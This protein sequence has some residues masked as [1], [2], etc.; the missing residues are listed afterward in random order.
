M[1][2]SVNTLFI[3]VGLDATFA[4]VSD[5]R[6]ATWDPRVSTATRVGPNAGGPIGIGATFVLRSPIALGLGIDFRYTI[7]DYDPP[8]RVRFTGKTWFARY[9]DDLTFTAVTDG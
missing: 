8:R 1:P 5:F 9:Q 2:R 4:Y 7:V 3:P 6:H